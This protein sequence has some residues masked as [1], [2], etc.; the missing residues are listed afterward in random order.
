MASPSFE[1]G[2]FSEEA[3]ALGRLL[4]RSVRDSGAL[5]TESLCVLAGE[6]VWA[7][8]CDVHVLDHDGN[9]ADCACLATVA[10]LSHFRR[11]DV[12]VVGD[13]VTVHSVDDRQPVGLVLHHVPVSVTF[14]FIADAALCVCD[15]LLREEQA[16]D[17]TLSVT[18]N[19]HKEVC[20]LQ[21]A[22]GL[23][24]PQEA[25][26]RCASVA[27]HKATELTAL[28]RQTLKQE[29]ERANKRGRVAIRA[30]ERPAP[31]QGADAG[32]EPRPVE[33][34]VVYEGAGQR[35]AAAAAVAVRPP[36]APP[37]GAVQPL[38][39]ALPGI[40]A[41][42][43]A[44]PAGVGASA[45]AGG[46]GGGGDDDDDDEEDLLPLAPAKSSA[47]SAAQREELARTL[48][49][50]APTKSA[51]PKPAPPKPSASSRAA[52]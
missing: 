5:D 46:G 22:G 6:R 15:P 33:S 18:V 52:K 16:A 14:C 12:T 51:Q 11:P 42:A 19:A 27:V 17:A 39:P 36:H 32:A 47:L 20:C 35:A 45:A 31:L 38:P 40:F 8:R 30:P 29:E 34:V 25:V 2:R 28:L 44:A 48:A 9:L 50:L 4:E 13:V 1:A 43:A 24:I 7:V 21:K 10:A 26:L 3:V 37:P 49:D 23:P 41:P